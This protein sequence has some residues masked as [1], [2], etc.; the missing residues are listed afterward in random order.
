MSLNRQFDRDIYSSRS[1]GLVIN[2]VTKKNYDN[3]S[4]HSFL[5]PHSEPRIL[6]WLFFGV[7]FCFLP[8]NEHIV[9]MIH[10]S[11]KK[12]FQKTLST[13]CFNRLGIL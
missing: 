12:T 5:I 8:L 11:P 2:L 3:F 7:E 6:M 13:N 9:F 1:F 10:K 4:Y